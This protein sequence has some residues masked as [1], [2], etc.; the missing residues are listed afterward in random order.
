[1]SRMRHDWQVSNRAKDKFKVEG[2]FPWRE[3]DRDRDREKR[4]KLADGDGA[5]S[6]FVSQGKETAADLHCASLS[7]FHTHIHTPNR[8]APPKALVL[9]KLGIPF[10]GSSISSPSLFVYVYDDAHSRIHTWPHQPFPNSTRPDLT[11]LD[12]SRTARESSK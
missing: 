11:R 6:L 8:K 5:V 10:R 4:A 2:V 7:L 3:G 1:M 9:E 12:S